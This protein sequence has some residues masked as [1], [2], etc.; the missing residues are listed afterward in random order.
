MKSMKLLLVL[1]L[2]ASASKAQISA[3]LMRDIDLSETQITFVYGGDIWLAP[4]AGGQ[5]LQLTNSPGEESYPKFSP[6]G[7]EIAFTASYSG[8]Q[9]VYVMPTSGGIPTRITYASYGDRMVD[10]HPN[11]QQILFASRREAGIPRVNQFFLVGKKGGFPEK[12]PV[13]YGELASFAPDGKK[14]AYITKITE[15]YPFKRYRGRPD[16]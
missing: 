4:K 9:D 8:N 3:K 11:G 12:M 14:L 13:P 15:N 10:W 16:F 7:S 2:I 6:D 5:A 1:L